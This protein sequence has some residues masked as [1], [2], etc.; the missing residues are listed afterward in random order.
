MKRCIFHY[1]FVLI[2]HSFEFYGL[3]LFILYE[4]P[5]VDFSMQVQ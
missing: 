5:K 2:S 1:L 3:F 4:I